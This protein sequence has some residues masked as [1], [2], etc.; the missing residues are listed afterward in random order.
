MKALILIFWGP[1][2]QGRGI[3]MGPP[4][5]PAIKNYFYPMRPFA[6]C[7]EQAWRPPNIATPLSF[8]LQKN[9]NQSFHLSYRLLLY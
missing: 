8:W 7:S 6:F 3:I 2:G 1:E 5:P 9:E 4:R